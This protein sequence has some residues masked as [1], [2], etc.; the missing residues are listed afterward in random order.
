MFIVGVNKNL[1]KESACAKTGWLENHDLRGW[2]AAEPS[3]FGPS[4]V[5]LIDS[6]AHLWVC[7]T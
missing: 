6:F 5:S 1:Q 7:V 4:L 2:N 3:D